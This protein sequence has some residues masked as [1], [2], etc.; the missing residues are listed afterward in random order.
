MTPT[1][2]TRR[3]VFFFG[4]RQSGA[5]DMIWSVA[6]GGALGSVVRFLL[7][8]AVQQRAATTFPIGTLIINITGSL[9]LGFIFRYAVATP[10]IAPATRLFLTTG[11]CGGYTT[12]STFSYETMNLIRDGEYLYCSLNVAASVMVGFAATF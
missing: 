2:N 9:V 7:G 4:L 5:R 11:F 6:L 10:A 12:F 3:G 1:R 8:M